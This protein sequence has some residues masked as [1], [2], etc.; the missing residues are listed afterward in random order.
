MNYDIDDLDKAGLLKPGFTLTACIFFLCRQVFFGPLLFLTQRSA[1]RG[2]ISKRDLDLSFME[3]ATLWE[4]IACLPAIVVLITL[5]L[6]KPAA[7]PLVRMI[8]LNGKSLL[9]VGVLA[10]ILV[11]VF[12]LFTGSHK[13]LDFNVLILFVH[14]L[15]L[16]YLLRSQRVHDSFGTFPKA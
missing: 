12:P 5:F 14:A 13:F 11:L 6:R 4:F 8:W 2:G 10:Q 7:A 1:K 15:L 3:V 9:L 16:F